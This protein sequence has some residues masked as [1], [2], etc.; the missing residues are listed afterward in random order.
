MSIHCNDL[1][2]P[3]D[4]VFTPLYFCLDFDE[5]I[6]ISTERQAYQ[7]SVALLVYLQS[8]RPRRH[9]L[10]RTY[11][12]ESLDTG[13]E[14]FDDY[15]E[16]IGWLDVLIYQGVEFVRILKKPKNWQWSGPVIS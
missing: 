10:V 11:W 1:R 14:Y 6:R 5:P 3:F 13:V 4:K 8:T 2:K 15:D 7:L 9:D 12:E 16:L